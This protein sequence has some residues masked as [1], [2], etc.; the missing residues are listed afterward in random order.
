MGLEVSIS[1]MVQQF[2][3]SIYYNIKVP[4]SNTGGGGIPDN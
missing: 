1:P 4:M 3:L 2:V